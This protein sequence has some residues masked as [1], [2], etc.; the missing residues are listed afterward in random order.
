MVVNGN[1]FTFD[2]TIEPLDIRHSNLYIGGHEDLYKI[3]SNFFLDSNFS[4]LDLTKNLTV[5][6]S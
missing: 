5:D 2:G 3:V 4:S 6:H 1:K